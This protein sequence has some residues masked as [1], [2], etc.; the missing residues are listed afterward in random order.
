M[1]FSF[2]ALRSTYV[3][4]AKLFVLCFPLPRSSHPFTHSL[5]TASLRWLRGP[6]FTKIEIIAWYSSGLEKQWYLPVLQPRCYLLYPQSSLNSRTRVHAKRRLPFCLIPSITLLTQL[7]KYPHLTNAFVEFIL[8]LK[9][10]ARFFL[11]PTE[12]VYSK[13]IACD[14]FFSS[15]PDATLW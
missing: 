2:S 4:L 8:K 15:A 11:F 7:H 1:Y 5:W 12:I 6:K 13:I 14:A 3:A 9:I 10:S